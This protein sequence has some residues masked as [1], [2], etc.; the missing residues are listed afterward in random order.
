MGLRQEAPARTFVEWQDNDDDGDQN[1]DQ[2]QGG[3][4]DDDQNQECDD[5]SS[6]DESSKPEQTM[7]QLPSSPPIANPEHS[8]RIHKNPPPTSQT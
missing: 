1:Q 4:D 7:K 6:K 3:D 5:E 2:N 8:P